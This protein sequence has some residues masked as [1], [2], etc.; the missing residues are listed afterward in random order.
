[1][2]FGMPTYEAPPPPALPELAQMT[3][4]QEATG[5][6]KRDDARR[7]LKVA[8]RAGTVGAQQS[9]VNKV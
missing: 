4:L 2:C 6:S 9:S 3:D 5:V 7:G 1:M 8:K